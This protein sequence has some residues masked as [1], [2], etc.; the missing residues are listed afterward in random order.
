MEGNVS[1][2]LSLFS[3]PVILRKA[4][5]RKIESHKMAIEAEPVG[6]S[7]A[8]ATDPAKQTQWKASLKRSALT[9]GSDSLT[10]VV[11]EVRLFFE[12][13]LGHKADHST[14]NR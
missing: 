13:I 6:L 5:E 11:G 1:G 10:E 14:G 7:N 12:P 2:F 9:T 4:I 8:F 3:V